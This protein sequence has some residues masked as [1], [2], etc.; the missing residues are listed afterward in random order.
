MNYLGVDFKGKPIFRRN[1]A[2]HYVTE[3]SGVGLGNVVFATVVEDTILI[4]DWLRIT[5]TQNASIAVAGVNSF[6]FQIQGQNFLM[7]DFYIPSIVGTP[8]LRPPTE[9]F[10]NFVN[11]FNTSNIVQ[12]KGENIS[13]FNP[14]AF[15]TGFYR[16]SWGWHRE[17]KRPVD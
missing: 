11:G 13:F 2:A 3:S 15:V 14:V 7:N 17:P 5:I 4:I 9:V 12:N 1:T 8:E 6:R 16:A 10:M